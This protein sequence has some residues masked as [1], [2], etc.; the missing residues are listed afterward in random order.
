MAC[1]AVADVPVGT[2]WE[3]ELKLDGYRAIGYETRNRVHLRSRNG[4]DFSHRFPALVR[5]LEPQPR[6]LI[7]KARR[8]LRTCA[9]VRASGDQRLP[10]LPTPNPKKLKKVDISKIPSHTLASPQ[11]LIG[12]KSLVRI[13]LIE[14]K[15]RRI[16]IG[17]QFLN[18]LMLPI[19]AVWSERLG[20]QADVAFT[21]F[22]RVD[23]DKDCD[24]VALSLYSFLA[25]QGYEVAG[26]F[27]ER[28][29][30][31]I[32][33]GP[34]TKG[35]MAEVKEHADLIFD[36]CNEAVWSQTLRG[37]EKK[38]ITANTR[39]GRFVPSLE[40]REIPSYLEIKRFY[41]NARIPLL[42]SSLGCPHDC[43][44]CSDWNSTYRKRDV[45]AVVEDVRNINE[46]FFIFCDP[47]FGVNRKFT[48][49]LLRK[50]IPLKKKY[51]MET[52]LV[53]LLDD[54]YL[55][56]LRDSG[57]IGIQIGVE[58][59]TTRYK[60]NGVKHAKP[61]LE[62]TIEN[63]QQ[64]KKYIPALQ[65]NIVLGFD[66]D[67]EE[68]FREVAEL[69]RRSK[70]DTLVPFIVTPLPGTPFFDR[71]R[72]EG[73]IFE[74]DWQYFN[75]SRLTITL[76]QFTPTH[77]YDLFIALY[78]ELHS[79][80]LILGK[81]FAHLKQYRSPKMAGLLSICLLSRFMNTFFYFVPDLKRAKAHA[82]LKLRERRNAGAVHPE[83]SLTA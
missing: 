68:T 58:S 54:E 80:W 53:W 21:D 50:M 65:V 1:V 22:T 26:R 81:I 35:N 79:P 43:D 56:L 8:I 67:T 59:L 31:V 55:K 13:Y 16:G 76:K 3:Y 51:M 18:S 39:P 24:V 32:I 45:D 75:C 7:T 37:I 52:S 70:I 57:C 72:A 41:G 30:V 64:I 62:E 78:K 40:M 46:S 63:I 25:P 83:T 19:L 5:A 74:N 27:R 12:A 48:S 29:K 14:L 6:K 71:M 28:G 44:F 36:R 11:S 33:G 60:K 69:Y 20:W 2:E 82:E 38:E 9:G 77:F 42:L 17:P 34:H 73:R 10:R 15:E 47:N 66:N 49:E 61:I 23:C 4:K